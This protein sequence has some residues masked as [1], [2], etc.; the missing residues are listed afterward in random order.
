MDIDR[1]GLVTELEF[2]NADLEISCCRIFSTNCES[3]TSVFS[4]EGAVRLNKEVTGRSLYLDD[5][6]SVAK[7]LAAIVE[8][9]N[10]V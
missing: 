2:L 6:V 3:F 5:K 7:F 10:A 8:M 1:T 9:E 4:C